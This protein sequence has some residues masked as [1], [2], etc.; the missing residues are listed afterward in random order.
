MRRSSKLLAIPPILL[1]A[2]VAFSFSSSL[3]I[4]V[5]RRAQAAPQAHAG[6]TSA[7]SS[8]RLKSTS[9]PK[10]S[11]TGSL[12]FPLSSRSTF[13]HTNND[14][15]EGYGE[16]PVGSLIINLESNGIHEH[17]TIEIVARGAFKFGTS[18]PDDA[19]AT[20]AVFSRDNTLLDPSQRSRVP[21]AIQTSQPPADTGPTYFGNEPTNIPEDFNVVPRVTLTVPA[22]AKFLFI[23]PADGV[24]CDNSDPN[25]D[26]GMQINLT[27]GIGGRVVD[28]NGNGI[29]G[30]T[31]T[32][33]GSTSAT[34]S[35][36]SSGSYSFTGL[37]A[38]GNYTVTPALATY[39]FGPIKQSVS[40]LSSNQTFDF[41]GG[42]PDIEIR[43]IEITQAIQD[44]QNSVVL[45]QN[46]RT[47]ARVHLK[48]I[49]GNV[50]GVSGKLIGPGGT[51]ATPNNPL[52]NG[53]LTVKQFP[54]RRN[55]NDSFYFELPATWN[56]GIQEFEFQ[57]PGHMPECFGLGLTQ[58]AKGCKI[59]VNYTPSR[60]LAMTFVPIAWKDAGGVVHQPTANDIFRTV[61]ELEATMPVPRLT[62]DRKP[63]VSP[64]QSILGPPNS[65]GDLKMIL[66]LLAVQQKL[67]SVMSSAKPYYMGV[68]I[69][70]GSNGGGDGSAGM[71]AEPGSVSCA[72]LDLS[73]LSWLE[74]PLSQLNA[75]HEFGHNLSQSHICLNFPGDPKQCQQHDGGKISPTNTDLGYFGFD[76]VT[77]HVYPPDAPDLMTYG[78]YPWISHD[79]YLGIRAILDLRGHSADPSK[80]PGV[81]GATTAGTAIIISGLISSNQNTAEFKST[82]ILPSLASIPSP[83]PGSYS[84]RFESAQGQTL[85]S[86]PFEPDKAAGSSDPIQFTLALP[87]TPGTTRMV[88]FHNAQAIASK[89]ASPHLPNITL[90]SPSGGA[91]ISGSSFMVTWQA[92]DL[93]GDALKYAVQLSRDNG[94]TWQ[95]LVSDLETTTLDVPTADLAGTNTALVRV[96]A[97]DGFNT[98]QAQTNATFTLPKHSP[99]VTISEPTYNQIYAD[100]QTINLVGMAYD[101][102]EGALAD[103]S[104]TWSLDG[105]ALQAGHHVQLDSSTLS[106]G[107]HCATLRAQDTDQ[108]TSTT[109]ICFYVENSPAQHA[110]DNSQFFVGQH[111]LDFLNRHPDP[112]GLAFWNGQ[113]SQCGNNQQCIE[114]KRINVS[115]AFY[116]SIEFQQTGYLVERM[117]KAAYGDGTGTSTL[118]G[119]HQLAVPV[120]RLNEFQPDT[121]QIGRGV[122][123]NQAGWEQVLEN[124]KQGFAAQ[125]VHRSRFVAAFPTT[126]S[127]AQFVDA[128]FTNAGVTPSATDRS[129]A[130][131]EFGSST[132]TTDLAARGRALRRVAE[133]SS[134]AS[135]EF[136]RAFVLMQYFGYLR[137]NPNDGQDTDY[138]GYDFW[139]RKLNQFNGNFQ[140]AEMVKAFITSGEYRRRFGL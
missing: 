116:L 93:D 48:G 59:Q 7:A 47:F 102:E 108:Q 124:N 40:N 41:T 100:K 106:P 37:M 107:I 22:G 129:T 76:A 53:A 105:S 60:P 63:Y 132:D 26:Y 58:T 9:V 52:I 71:A 122:V 117:Y 25:G 68:L 43:G 35:T 61:Q 34:T 21:G 109:N 67:D 74:P 39:I 138:T 119:N 27:S 92:S 82:Y 118:G 31:M 84:I 54:A 62:W 99:S 79:A 32:L 42:K 30:V 78:S 89:N 135:S 120:V 115:A 28:Q 16:P 13:L 130:V 20:I 88:L 51:V 18:L 94:G 83:A 57:T 70:R 6:P 136:N 98:A 1:V 15:C 86:F 125:F 50:T 5:S 87:W 75:S 66:R 4:P 134:L 65:E 123:V 64:L 113:F 111:Y 96:L 24:Y 23:A 11:Q 95:T 17:D 112:A 49:A 55:L 128:L 101:P 38:G 91:V 140:N 110:L 19:N 69:D 85:A 10:A 8:Q 36:D 97:S 126:M 14:I 72:Y 77:K 45:I 29:N 73:Q 3:S 133:N 12:T 33:S 121:Q 44:L 127:P 104:L 114:V 103:S 2:L 137:R 80:S 139:L 90:S 131:N 46:K 81:D 56:T